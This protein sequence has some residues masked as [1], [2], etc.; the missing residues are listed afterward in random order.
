MKL[1]NFEFVYPK[2]FYLIRIGKFEDFL[3][4]VVWK[5]KEELIAFGFG[6]P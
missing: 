4:G 2:V 1:V 5:F 3:S 6:Y